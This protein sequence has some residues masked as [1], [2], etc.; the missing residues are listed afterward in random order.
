MN[1]STPTCGW[2]ESAAPKPDGG[3]AFPVEFSTAGWHSGNV[4][5]GM[6]LR[7]FFAGLAMAGMFAE[8]DDYTFAGISQA[9]YECADAMI[10]EREKEA[11]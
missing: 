5:V 10:A 6:T 11:R 1:D 4:N 2:N 7:D 8:S 3:P 9:A